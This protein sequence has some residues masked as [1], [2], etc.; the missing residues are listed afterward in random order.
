MRVG[1][2]RLRPALALVHPR[3]E[4]RL[5]DVDEGRA[6]GNQP[7]QHQREVTPLLDVFGGEACFIALICS[8]ELNVMFPVELRERLISDAYSGELQGV[9]ALLERQRCPLLEQLR[10]DQP[11]LQVGAEHAPALVGALV[12]AKA[13]AQEGG[14]DK[15]DSAG[16]NVQFEADLSRSRVDR[17]V[18]TGVEL[19]PSVH[20]D[21][22][23]LVVG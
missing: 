1:L 3:G 6:P 12:A 9:T 18:D 20:D 13:P 10:R 16:G 19:V 4:G 5:V 8:P 2:V 7:A 11:L 22:P 23:D 15:A 14:H 17:V 21:Q